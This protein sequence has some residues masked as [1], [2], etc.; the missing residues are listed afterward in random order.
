VSCLIHGYVSVSEVSEFKN[1]YINLVKKI[2][3]GV[4][5]EEEI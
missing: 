4:E 3:V 1:K 5:E 2:S